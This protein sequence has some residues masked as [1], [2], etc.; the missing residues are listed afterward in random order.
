M[1]IIKSISENLE[2]GEQTSPFLFMGG[3][4]EL[5]NAQAKAAALE[6]CKHFWV[7]EVAF[8]HLEETENALKIA[9][10]KT[11]FKKAELSSPYKIQ[12][13]L[14]ENI[15]RLT[16]SAGNSCLKLFEEPWVQN[17]IFLTNESESGVLETILSRVNSV[18][19]QANKTFKKS[20]F[21]FSLIE[22]YATKRDSEIFSYFFKSKLE[23]SEYIYFLNNVLL[24]AKQNGKYRE[25]ME[26]INEDIAMII[27]NNV[28]AKGV[29]DK[30]LLMM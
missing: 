2:K 28:N 7:P 4:L 23:K 19:I 9:D 22:W 5:V 6:L 27:K 10:I 15:S 18:A 25:L 13:F 11:F 1:D 3:N 29:V 24:Y 21:Y 17:I 16:L 26:D 8:S 20:D 12:I 30:Y 14:L